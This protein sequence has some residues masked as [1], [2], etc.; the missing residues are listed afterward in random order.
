MTLRNVLIVVVLL[1]LAKVALAQDPAGTW[2]GVTSGA[3]GLAVRPITLVLNADGT[4]TLEVDVVLALEEATID[5][6]LLAFAVR[7]MIGGN[8]A[9]F[10]LR[11]EGGA[12]GDTMTLHVTME[13]GGGGLGA[14]PE[15]LVLTRLSSAGAASR[16]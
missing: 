6:S 16:P 15:P 8:P 13:G 5:G 14:D 4:G 2:S 7:P 10:R 9:G 11:Y 12:E 3:G 1:N